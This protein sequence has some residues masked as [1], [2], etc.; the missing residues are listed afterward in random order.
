MTTHEITFARGTCRIEIEEH[1]EMPPFTAHVAL[2]DADGGTV[3]PLVF[4]TGQRVEIHATSE[5]LALSSAITY[6][7][8]RFGSPSELQHGF[9]PGAQ[10]KPEGEPFVIEH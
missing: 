5:P 2:L 10:P 9:L 3:H 7:E 4:N 8:G 1:P 6:L